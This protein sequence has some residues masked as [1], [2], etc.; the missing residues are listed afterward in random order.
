MTGNNRITT[1]EAS[2]IL[3]ITEQ[4][5]RISMQMGL[6]DIGF[7]YGNGRRKTY[8]I[9]EEKVRRLRNGIV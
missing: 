8:I 3:G 2:K 6:I 5:L 7:V 9:Y 1:K 4:M